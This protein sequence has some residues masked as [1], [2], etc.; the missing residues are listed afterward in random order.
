M[1][2]R[3]PHKATQKIATVEYSAGAEKVI[4]L[5]VGNVIN[6]TMLK[7]NYGYSVGANQ[8]GPTFASCVRLIKRVEMMINGSD[9]FVSLDAEA[10]YANAR[11]D[12]GQNPRGF[13]N[14]KTVAGDTG[15]IAVNI[16]IYH[17]VPGLIGGD[18]A[19]LDLRGLDSCTLRI[20][21]ADD[22]TD[23]LVKSANHT[24]T[25]VDLDV[26]VEMTR[27]VPS[28]QPRHMLRELM[29]EEYE[30]DASKNQFRLKIPRKQGKHIHRA[31]MYQTRNERVTLA[32]NIGGA[33]RQ[34]IV[35]E[36]AAYAGAQQFSRAD[37]EH[38]NAMYAD[39]NNTSLLSN[40]V[41]ITTSLF[42][43]PQKMLDTNVLDDDLTFEFEVDGPDPDKTAKIGF[44]TSC[45]RPIRGLN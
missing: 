39:L 34:V 9:R 3:Y 35:G 11:M 7:L 28:T 10:L 17:F 21:W 30:V 40:I 13:E 8:D 16:P 1:G 37:W 23:A 19:A 25:N 41:P 42:G 6:A 36:I 27:D 4:N 43:E 33:Q 12:S 45:V 31:F 18:R 29:Y 20:V 15:K 14:L 22:L 32:S 44:V 5:P 26:T 24:L 38:H 2:I